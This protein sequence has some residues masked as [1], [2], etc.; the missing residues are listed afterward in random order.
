MRIALAWLFR[1]PVQGLAVLGCAVGLGSLLT[2]LAVLNGLVEFDRN[3]VRGPL[4]DLIV[5]PPPSD[6]PASWETWKASLENAPAVEATAPH[7]IA[8]ALWVSEGGEGR[9]ASTRNSD[10]NGI[11]VVGID[12]LAESR[13]TGFS[14]SLENAEFPPQDL[15]E[16][17]G[18][19]AGFGSR[20]GIL[21]SDTLSR[22]I[23]RK[24]GHPHGVDLELAA[25]PPFL[26]PEGHDLVPANGR[27]RVMG[28]YQSSDYKMALD[29]VLVQR[30]GR[31]GLRYNLLGQEAPEFTE[32]LIKLKP[33]VSLEDGRKSVL[34]TL[35]A[36]GL[37]KPGGPSGGSL[38]T[39]EERQSVFLA[40]IDNERR[41][42]TLVLFFVVI[43][44]AFGLFAVVGALVREKIQEL[45]ILAALGFSPFHRAGLI[46]VV[47][48]MAALTGSLLGLASAKLIVTHRKAVED[49]L[50]NHLGF[51]LFR[52]DLYVMN[53]IPALWDSGQ[54]WLLTLACFGVGLLFIL[55][56]AIR[57]AFLRPVH[58]L[59]YE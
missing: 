10:V 42:L 52:K 17:F 54:A 58:A 41:V 29:R 31:G 23:P 59:R 50:E 14:S 6:P 51:V 19:V 32:A 35:A 48:G 39:W 20:P 16:P 45:G 38:E 4:S 28:T 24:N 56:P 40:A 47:G 21:I 30:T 25:L 15:R 11:Q 44:A 18:A 3:A 9:L 49:F 13:V 26:P 36:S 37:P 33:G 22:A 43:V 1:R 55:A 5:M 57:A 27:F 34:A 8:Y 2:V 53:E 46:L 12:P 7:L